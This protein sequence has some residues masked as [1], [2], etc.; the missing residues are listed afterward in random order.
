MGNTVGSSIRVNNYWQKK[1]IQIKLSLVLTEEQKSVLIGSLL[2]DGTLRLG[3]G[4]INVNFKVEHGLAQKDYVFWKYNIFQPWVFTEPKISYRY[5]ESRERYAKSWWFRTV[6]HPILTDFRKR[7]YENGKKIIPFDIVK[8]LNNLAMAV[9]VMDDGC[10]SRNTLDISTYS[11]TLPEV[12]LL[13][14]ALKSKFDLRARYHRDRDKGYR[15]YLSINE[16]KKLVDIIKPYMVPVM[17]YKV[18]LD[19]TP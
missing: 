13:I 6:R 12:E 19:R 1:W 5:K 2:G 17:N 7:F 8:D 18:A 3:E 10:L 9:W 16:T 14:E 11:F 15:M 4:A